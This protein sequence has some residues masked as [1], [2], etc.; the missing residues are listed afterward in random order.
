MIKDNACLLI[1][2]SYNASPASMIAALRD[3]GEMNARLPLAI[4]T[5][6]LE[7]GD[8]SHSAHLQL[9]EELI[10]N[11]IAKV[12]TAGPL[13][14]QICASLPEQIAAV[15]FD[16]SDS[17]IHQLKKDATSLLKPSDVLLV[18]GSHGSGAYKIA[19]HLINEFTHHP[20][21]P[22]KPDGGACHAA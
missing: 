14:R 22:I 1:D 8:H 16:D 10:Q 15:S 2:D 19:Q 5:D 17:L 11:G 3:L 6:M 13:M 9:A 20:S 7:L 18:K 21:A 4:L 12:I